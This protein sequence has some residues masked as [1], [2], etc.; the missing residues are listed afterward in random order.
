[1]HM[2]VSK[3]RL[4]TGVLLDAG[5]EAA[6]LWC[7]PGRRWKVEVVSSSYRQ[8]SSLRASHPANSSCCVYW[9]WLYS[10][11]KLPRLPQ[12]KQPRHQVR[13]RSCLLSSVMRLKRLCI[14][15]VIV[16]EIVCHLLYWAGC[17]SYGDCIIQIFLTL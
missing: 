4:R 16:S 1:M 5:L 7:T 17:F 8:S 2:L 12:R 13:A 15:I 10:C 11:D 9:K 3:F 14:E 6:W